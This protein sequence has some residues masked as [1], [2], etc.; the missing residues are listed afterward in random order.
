M[1]TTPDAAREWKEIT[2]N[3]DGMGCDHCVSAVREAV[4][5]IDSV[6][7][8]DADVG[9]VAA[10]FDPTVTNRIELA[11]AIADAGFTVVSST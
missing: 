4:S 7:V 10:R 11:A 8:L 5:E 3:I 1:S 9:S 6:D 2:F